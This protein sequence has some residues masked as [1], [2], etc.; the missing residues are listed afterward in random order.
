M[1]GW[2]SYNADLKKPEKPT[3]RDFQRARKKLASLRVTDVPAFFRGSVMQL[4]TWGSSRQLHFTSGTNMRR[5]AGVQ[6]K[7]KRKKPKVSGQP[8][9]PV[10]RSGTL[11]L[12]RDD[13]PQLPKMTNETPTIRK[14]EG[15]TKRT[16]ALNEWAVRWEHQGADFI[17]IYLSNWGKLR[18]DRSKGLK[19]Q[20]R[21]VCRGGWFLICAEDKGSSDWLFSCDFL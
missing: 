7:R 19:D 13:R 17:R 10:L 18:H 16:F 15:N 1:K 9:P 2:K 8:W 6:P 12:L 4:S 11:P 20:E 3:A 5:Q 21:R 14:Q